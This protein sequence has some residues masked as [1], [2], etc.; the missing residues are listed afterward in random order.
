MRY[1]DNLVISVAMLLEPTVA[2][3]L[4][5]AFNVGN[6]PGLQG[7]IGNVLVM[8]GTFA[9]VYQPGAKVAPAH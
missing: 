5:A 8:I 9:V 1:F 4:A 3:L 7:W 2:E 6:L